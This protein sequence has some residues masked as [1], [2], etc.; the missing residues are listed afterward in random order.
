MICLKQKVIVAVSGGP[1]S[2]ALLHMLSLKEENIVVAHVNYHQRETSHRDEKLVENYANKL[3][4]IF[5]KK[6]F[7]LEV[8]DNFQKM[9]RNFRYAFFKKLYI[10]YDAKALYIGHHL[11][12]DI[13]TYIMQKTSKRITNTPGILENSIFNKMHIRRPLLSMSKKEIINYCKVHYVPYGIDESNLEDDYTR[14]RIRH[15]LDKI[16]EQEK[17]VLLKKLNAEKEKRKSY[18]KQLPVLSN[19]FKVK[20]YQKINKQERLD[21]LRYFFE[22]NGVIPYDFSLKFMESLDAQILGG[23]MQHQFDEQ[24]L[25]VSYGEVMLYEEKKYRYKLDTVSYFKTPYFELRDT[26]ETIEGISLSEADFPI[27]IRNYEP[28]DKIKM[29]FG[30]KS[31]NRFFIDRKIPMHQRVSWPIV[32]NSMKE[33]VFVVGLGCDIHHYANNPSIFMVKL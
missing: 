26:G 23:K 27:T 14:N 30:T 31:V 8:D 7:D 17:A 5:E 18:L 21:A 19:P 2:M 3:G 22:N 13:E 11:D 32:E 16:S 9:A 25:S 15:A 10:K 6:D 12:D 28:G 24:I 20:D 4:A 1:D 33:V 29:R